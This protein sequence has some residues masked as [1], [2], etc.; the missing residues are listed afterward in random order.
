MD[1]VL[2]DE[3]PISPTLSSDNSSS[4]LHSESIMDDSFVAVGEI[5]RSHKIKVFLFS[6][7]FLRQC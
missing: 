7:Y 1:V 3:I 4:S 6:N 2:E 5:N